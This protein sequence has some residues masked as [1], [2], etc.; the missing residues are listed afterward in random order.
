MIVCFGNC[1]VDLDRRELHVAGNPVHMEPQVFDLLAELIDKRDRVVSKDEIIETVWHGRIV[2]EAT[3]GSR[4]NS[5]RQAIGDSG[6]AQTW[7]R[8]IPRRGFRFIGDVRTRT[9]AVRVPADEG[10]GAGSNL[11]SGFGAQQQVTFCSTPDGVRLAVALVGKGDALVKTANWLN[12][13][14]FDWQSPVW[15]P[16]FGRWAAR[17]RL[18]RYDQRGTGLSD[19]ETADISFE[20]FVRDLEAVIESLQLERFALFGIS[21]GGAV[22]IA[23]AARHPERVSKL[24]LH[25]TYALGRTKRET[26]TDDEQ[27]EAYLTL[28]RHG[29]GY[30][31]SAFMQAF[32]SLYIPDGTSE[33]I[34]WFSELQ[35]VTT[36]PENAVRIRTACDEIDVVDLLPRVQAPTLVTHCRNDNVVPFDHGRT[37]ASSIRGARF[38][39]LESSNHASLPGE[40]AWGRFM[41]EIEL[42]L[43]A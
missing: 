32:S 35:R 22:A 13:V 41:T 11:D 21:Q 34:K 12:H 20:A 3:L 14:E 10:A 9:N 36:S 29:W 2:S 43:S 19:W 24:I 4:I 6:K 27:A 42:F 40:K 31:N 15:A 28:I 38:V 33:Q 17:N 25:G 16:T 7:I 8:T 23:Y 26:V 30:P 39:G 18:I 37:I 1:E 5:V